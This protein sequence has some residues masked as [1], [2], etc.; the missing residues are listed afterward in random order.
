MYILLINNCYDDFLVQRFK[1]VESLDDAKYWFKDEVEFATLNTVEESNKETAIKKLS[2]LGYKIT[3]TEYQFK[4]FLNEN[5]YFSIDICK[6][7]EL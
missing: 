6:I 2:Q 5:N 4:A 3:D 7:E 1:I